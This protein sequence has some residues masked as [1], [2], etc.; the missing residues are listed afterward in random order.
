MGTAV[1]QWLRCCATSRK[2]AGSIPASVNGFFIDIKSF[3]SHY[4]PGVDTSDRLQLK[5]DSTRW[6]TGGEVKGKLVEWVA[7]ALHTTSEHCVS[8]ITTAD[9][10]TSAA[11]SRLNWRPHRFKWARPFRRKTNSDFCACA[12]T[13]QLSLLTNLPP[14]CAVCP[15]SLGASTPGALSSCIG[16]GFSYYLDLEWPFHKGS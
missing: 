10:H 11:S 9:A 4:G 1:A 13:F 12:I 16:I 6:R 2:V 3:R 5:C 14:T 8:S 15:K 7:S